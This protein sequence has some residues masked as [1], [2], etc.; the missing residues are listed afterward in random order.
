M[1]SDLVLTRCFLKRYFFSALLRAAVNIR[2]KRSGVRLRASDN[3][4]R[5]AQATHGALFAAW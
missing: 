1:R 4:Q 3:F 2:K 5:R